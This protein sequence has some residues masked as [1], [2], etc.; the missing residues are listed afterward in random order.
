MVFFLNCAAKESDKSSSINGPSIVRNPKNAMTIYDDSPPKVHVVGFA[1]KQSSP[2]NDD[3]RSTSGDSDEASK[4]TV[5][6]ENTSLLSLVSK[7]NDRSPKFSRR[8][9]S[10]RRGKVAMYAEKKS[11]GMMMS[12][13]FVLAAATAGEEEQL[14]KSR[15]QPDTGI[16]KKGARTLED[17]RKLLKKIY[18]QG[19][20]TV[21]IALMKK[22]DVGIFVK[23]AVLQNL[24]VAEKRTSFIDDDPMLNPDDDSILISEPGDWDFIDMW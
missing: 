10:E 19:R 23:S 2:D 9:S 4:P 13:A 3:I 14:K 12:N 11:S 8:F 20:R 18:H 7:R 24:E 15:S 16:R 1:T 22:V 17:E 6:T 21:E 5:L